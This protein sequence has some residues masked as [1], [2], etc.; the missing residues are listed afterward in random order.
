[1]EPKY[2][3]PTI[4]KNGRIALLTMEDFNSAVDAD[5]S[6]LL[7]CN[8]SVSIIGAD[9]ISEN[10][11]SAYTANISEETFSITEFS[12]FYKIIITEGIKVY[13][14]TG[15][16]ANYFSNYSKQFADLQTSYNEF[17][18]SAFYNGESEE[19]FTKYIYTIDVEAT[20]NC[21]TSDIWDA[22]KD[23]RYFRGKN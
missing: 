22:I 21:V 10:S 8:G 19:E 14:K 23:M 5:K 6:I 11:Y 16:C 12:R 9:K 3:S 1:M 18:H 20:K 13:M 2:Y 17:V 7:I 15:Y 4:T